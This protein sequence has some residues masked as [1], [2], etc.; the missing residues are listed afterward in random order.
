FTQ[1]FLIIVKNQSPV[2]IDRRSP[3][4]EGTGWRLRCEPGSIVSVKQWN[5]CPASILNPIYALQRQVANR[6]TANRQTMMD[7][8]KSVPGER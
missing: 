4:G 3:W 8:V 6:Q 1:V 2:Q 5:P 7:W